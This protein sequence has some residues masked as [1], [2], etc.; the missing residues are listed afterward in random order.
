M[1]EKPE[2]LGGAQKRCAVPAGASTTAG[3][4]RH[5]FSNV[6]FKVADLLNSFTHF[7]KFSA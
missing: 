3:R 1:P 5:S 2:D 4:V 7:S 6:S